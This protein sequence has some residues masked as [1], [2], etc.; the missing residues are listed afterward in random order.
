M[1]TAGSPVCCRRQIRKEAR[2]VA[3]FESGEAGFAET[4]HTAAFRRGCVC[5]A[6]ASPRPLFV[7]A[8]TLPV[9]SAKTTQGSRYDR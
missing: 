8:E 5:P 1:R 6:H 9:V 3:H 2:E 4:I 7:W